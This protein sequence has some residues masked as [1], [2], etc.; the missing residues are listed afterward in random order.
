MPRESIENK[1]RGNGRRKWAWRRRRPAAKMAF[2]LNLLVL[3]YHFCWLDQSS[4]R[5]WW[6][7]RSEYYCKRGKGAEQVW[8][9]LERERN[10]MER[11]KRDGTEHIPSC[12]ISE[13]SGQ[14]RGGVVRPFL[15]WFIMHR[16]RETDCLCDCCGRASSLLRLDA[17]VCCF[18]LGKRGKKRYV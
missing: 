12:A 18:S 10:K 6:R 13:R 16:S 4:S 9:I 5:W 14:E 17:A 1:F 3:G 15:K 2:R 7:R 11:G 8:C